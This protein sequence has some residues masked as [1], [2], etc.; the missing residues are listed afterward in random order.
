M[1]RIEQPKASKG[2]Q[3]W[4]QILVNRCPQLLN[5]QILPQMG[6]LGAR[7]EWLSPLENDR[8]AEYRYQDFLERLKIQLDR[9]PLKS[10]WPRRGPQWDALGLVNGK[11]P[12]LLEAK[13]HIAE[14]NSP[15]SQARG[16][17]RDKIRQSLEEAR[18]FFCRRA[19]SANDKTPA[20]DWLTTFYQYTNR[21][22]HLYLL[23][24]ANRIPAHLVFLYF[25]NAEDVRGPT[26]REEWR[27][28]TN[29]CHI[30]LGIGANRSPA[31]VIDAFV[32]VA[33]LRE[34]S[35]G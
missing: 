4:L 6:G 19:S 33:D 30:L 21:L 11:E 7:I 3:R 34:A 17:S 31:H 8:Y 13:A 26:T 22:A 29:P 15:A 1:P 23:R 2:S 27:G 35:S 14:L 9:R 10:F 28:A 16:P 32:D 25:V 20:R 5:E 12:I 24:E 18:R